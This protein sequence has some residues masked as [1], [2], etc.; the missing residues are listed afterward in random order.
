MVVRAEERCGGASCGVVAAVWL[1]A[2]ARPQAA[3]VRRDNGAVVAWEENGAAAVRRR[4]GSAGGER[5]GS[6]AKERRR[7]GRT[8]VRLRHGG[9]E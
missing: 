5:R 3:R 1:R 6:G 7:H 4:G 2:V 9:D 8:T